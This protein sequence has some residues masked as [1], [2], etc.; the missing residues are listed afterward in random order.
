[1]PSKSGY[2]AVKFASKPK[3]SKQVKPYGLYQK[4]KKEHFGSKG[5]KDT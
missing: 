5:L 2:D 4:K 3:L 1:M